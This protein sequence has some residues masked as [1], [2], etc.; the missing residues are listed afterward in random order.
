M[1]HQSFPRNGRFHRLTR[2]DFRT[3]ISHWPGCT[4]DTLSSEGLKDGEFLQIVRDAGQELGIKG[5]EVKCWPNNWA[6]VLCIESTRSFRDLDSARAFVDDIFNKLEPI[7][8][9]R[10]Q[11]HIGNP[12]HTVQFQGDIAGAD[13]HATLKYGRVAPV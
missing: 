6:R 9:R 7:V 10:L 13:L 5:L 4:L 1:Q 2:L 12:H 8:T 11:E 3:F